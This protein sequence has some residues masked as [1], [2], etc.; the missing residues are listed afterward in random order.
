MGVDVA[1]ESTVMTH[2]LPRPANLEIVEEM[3]ATV[4]AGGAV[5]R[6]MGVV[7]GEVRVGLEGEA[8]RALAEREEV[9]KVGLRDLPLMRPRG[10]WGGTTVSATLHLAHGA[11][12]P[13]F[14]TGG[15]G[16]VHRGEAW[17]VSA[18]LPALASIP[19]TVVCAGPK[20]ILD[21]DRTRE[22]LE[23][24]GVI[25]L[26]W[27]TDEFPAFYCRESG[28]GVDARVEAASEVAEVMVERN[29]LGLRASVL[30]TVPCPEMHALPRD[31]MRGLIAEAHLEAEALG[32]SGKSLTP[33]LLKRLAERT[34][35]RSLQANRA[36]L[37]NN[38]RVAAEIA[39]AFA[40]VRM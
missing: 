2:G 19:G 27:K 28:Q 5:P 33:H 39:S 18:D 22:R 17:D 10:A 40:A 32:V 35:G 8:L 24:D 25:V 13:V 23:T 11:G 38:A 20:S 12:I 15:I 21:V 1:L 37:L 30:V 6:V 7:G 29:R 4:R 31:E 14:A 3:M 26:G 36:L 9:R 34:D 16:G